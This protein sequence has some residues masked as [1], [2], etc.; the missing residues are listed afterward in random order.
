MT[1]TR[2]FYI[3]FN[4]QSGIPYYYEPSSDSTTYYKPNEGLILDP[5][6]QQQ[7]L[8]PEDESDVDD[9]KISLDVPDD[10]INFNEKDI[11]MDDPITKRDASFMPCVNGGPAYLP[12]DLQND[13]KKFQI[14]DFARQFFRSHRGNH[15]FNRKRISVEA[16][17]EFSSDQL[18]EP[19]L[20]AIDQKTAKLAISAFKYILYYTGVVACKNNAVYA[21][22]LVN[23][24]Y[25]NPA[26]RDEIMFQLI[27]QTRNNPNP[28]WL[29][30]TWELFVIVVTVF[31]SSR[32]SEEWIKSHLAAESKNSNE[33]ISQYASFAYIRFSARCAL[34]KP[35]ESSNEINM[36]QKIPNQVHL[37][38][39]IFGASLYEQIWNQRRSM[40]KLPIPFILYHMA[41][42]L[43][44][45]NCE[46]IEGIFRLPGNLRKVDEIADELNQGRD[47]LI[48]ADINDIAS[49]MKKW[50]RDLPDPVIN[51]SRVDFLENAFEDKNYLEFVET[52]PKTHKLTLMFL[53]GFLQHLAQS[54]EVT[55]MNAK[56]LAIVFGPNIV[57]IRDTNEPFKIKKFAD[58]TIDF[59]TFL[60]TSWDTSYIYPLSQEYLK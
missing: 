4:E 41:D 28:D 35:M 20:E 48:S 31:P 57:Q 7:F 36:Y 10:V 24:M 58:I 38:R 25:S 50:F 49:L 56:N 29:K 52:L 8:F 51:L 1:S 43:L 21:D 45:K 17:T 15:K 6:T 34:G 54:E 26:L 2:V 16:L 47:S 11:K 18:A 3:Y 55:K 14:T 59:M 12:G 23:L 53:V 44:K 37:G 46:N 60:V 27:K 30:K 22:R 13:I 5:E 9:V 40:M 19:L 39:K 32:N 42:I 33:V